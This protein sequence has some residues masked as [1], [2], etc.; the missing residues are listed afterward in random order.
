MRWLRSSSEAEMVALFLRTELPSDR[1]KDDL[2]AL[3]GRAGLPGREIR[4]M[5]GCPLNADHEDGRP[6]PGVLRGRRS[7]RVCTAAGGPGGRRPGDH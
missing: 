3:L 1:W 5:V 4:L 6:D 7:E 2:R